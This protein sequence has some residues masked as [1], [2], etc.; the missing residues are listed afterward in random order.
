MKNIDLHEII[1][2]A[3]PIIMRCAPKIKPLIRFA[4]TTAGHIQ[5]EAGDL[6]H[7]KDVN[8]Y[9][10]SFLWEPKPTKIARE[11]SPKPFATLQMQFI[12]G[13]PVFFKPTIAEVI[14]QIPE[15]DLERTVGF[16]VDGNNVGFTDDSCHHVANVM[17]YGWR[18]K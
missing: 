11:V 16:E 9:S 14:A 2:N 6:Y 8:I 5:H 15:K 10:R 17:L 13:A 3:A 1:R 4:K 18:P 7:I 12:Y